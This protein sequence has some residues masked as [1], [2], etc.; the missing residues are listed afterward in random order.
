MK[1]VFETKKARLSVLSPIHIGSFEQRLT[2]FEYVQSGQYVYPV[3]DDRLSQFLHKKKLI[4]TYTSAVGREGHRFR[5]LSFFKEN[6]FTPSESDLLE[7]SSG[8]KIR[9]IGDTLRLQDYRPF[10]RDGFGNIYVPGTS[11]K[12]VM[13]TGIL[14]NALIDFKTRQPREFESQVLNR[15]EGTETRLFKRKYPF[16]WIQDNY[17]EDFVLS[18]KTRSPNT[19]WL[20]MFHV[21]DAYPVNLRE[22][23]LLPVNVLKK[24]RDGWTYRMERAGQ[25]TTIW[26]EAVPQSTVF[27]VE[28]AWD[29]KLHRL[30]KPM[31]GVSEPLQGLSDL[32]SKVDK[33]AKD[34]IEYEKRFATGH[35]LCNWYSEK[36]A[37]IRIG[38]GSGM[39]A[40][41][42][43]L[44]LPENLRKKVRNLSG[45][46]RGDDVAPKSRRVWIDK[47]MPIPL[48]WAALEF[49]E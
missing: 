21:R 25:N 23:I 33:F 32:L 11:L 30:F 3:S 34:I 5:L 12:G 8:R 22:T 29:K 49:V 36:K 44:L 39:T 28:L 10:I 48:G 37:N 31:Q 7:I 46:N 4:D 15:I 9:V 47:D 20:R 24:E 43:L 1:D 45:F 35:R 40:T 27:E 2:P 41:T 26:V 16:Q 14:Y 13:R 42:I 18:K 38:F 17:L 19:D 6:R